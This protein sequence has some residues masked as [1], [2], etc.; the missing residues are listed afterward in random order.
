M[1]FISTWEIM[2]AGG[3][4]TLPLVWNGDYDFTVD[5]ADGSAP[6]DITTYNSE[7]VSH[8]YSDSGNYTIS[9]TG[10]IE[11][12]KCASLC[13]DLTSITDWGPLKL[14][15]TGSYFYPAPKLQITTSSQLNLDGTVLFNDFF[16]GCDVLDYDISSWDVSQVT[17]MHA[18]FQA[19]YLFNQD[20]SAW[21]VSQVRTL[22][23]TFYDC[24]AFNQVSSPFNNLDEP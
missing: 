9:I 4:V 14:G 24:Y 3:S 7:D 10:T 2:D 18:M 21:D 20:L 11:G 22:G 17:S 15:N 8:V 19:A 12:W 16:H 6:V 1:A 23:H 13:A 5:W